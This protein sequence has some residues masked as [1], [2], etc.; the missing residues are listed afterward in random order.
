MRKRI[1]VWAVLGFWAA[2]ATFAVQGPVVING[3]GGE[4]SGL[5]LL[6]TSGQA[7][8][9]SFEGSV[10][11][12][13]GGGTDTFTLT[14]TNAGQDVA[15]QDFALPADGQSHPVAFVLAPQHLLVGDLVGLTILD[16]G[17]LGI[18]EL[19]DILLLTSCTTQG[20]P[21]L[22]GSALAG[23]AALLGVASVALLARRRRAVAAR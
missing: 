10:T 14:L 3:Q 12:D 23:F 16:P 11:T 4:L 17:G 22:G 19:D 2:A 1:G 20:I 15:S 9:V 7:C 5:S 18:I 6:L 8:T 21:T 13:V